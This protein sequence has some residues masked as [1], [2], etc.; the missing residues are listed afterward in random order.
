MLE[1]FPNYV[2]MSSNQGTSCLIRIKVIRKDA[3]GKFVVVIVVKQHVSSSLP[4]S[5]VN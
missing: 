2:T 1:K 3:S 5:D 4:I